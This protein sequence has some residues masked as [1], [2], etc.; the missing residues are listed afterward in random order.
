MPC[1]HRFFFL[2][3]IFPFRFFIFSAIQINGKRAYD[4]ARKGKEVKLKERSVQFF[5]L[6]VKAF[7]WP[8]LELEV[9]CGSGT[10]VRSLAHDLGKRLGCGGYV[11]C[12]YV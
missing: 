2:T 10:Y 11:V 4:L 9:H 6:K 12:G 8:L 5:D 1:C 7:A 3:E